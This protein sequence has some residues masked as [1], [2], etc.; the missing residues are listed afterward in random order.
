MKPLR[1]STI[2]ICGTAASGTVFAVVWSQCSGSA[3][4]AMD[5]VAALGL[6][7]AVGFGIFGFPALA[8]FARER[9]SPVRKAQLRFA[10]FTLA[11]L[12]AVGWLILPC[13]IG[14]NWV[15]RLNDHLCGDHAFLRFSEG[16]V[17]FYHDHSRPED[18]GRYT[19][20]GWHTY[21]WDCAGDG[22]KGR[23]IFVHGGW[24]FVRFTGVYYAPTVWG[25]RDLALTDTGRIIRE[26]QAQARKD[27]PG[28]R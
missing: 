4:R 6:G 27:E 11:V 21:R 10:A 9:L 15:S 14:G 7:V 20:A 1:A 26:G 12:L 22:N 17:T 24:L 18:W 3:T 28:H 8:V 19:R 5:I 16:R 13:P 23:P 2:L 25:I